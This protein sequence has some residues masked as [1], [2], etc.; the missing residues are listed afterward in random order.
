MDYP[1]QMD[2][3]AP[4]D[5]NRPVVALVGLALVPVVVAMA[6]AAVVLSRGSGGD[7]ADPPR[8]EGTPSANIVVYPTFANTSPG[9]TQSP[10]PSA[11]GG[12]PDASGGSATPGAGGG[13]GGGGGGSGGGGSGGG[14]S[15]GGGGGGGAGGGGGGSGGGGSGGG[16][17]TTTPP[18]PPPTITNYGCVKNGRLRFT[19]TVQYQAPGSVQIR[20]TQYNQPVPSW[21]DLASVQG[22]CGPG[23][24]VGVGV[25]VS[26]AGGSD[27]DSRSVICPDDPCPTCLWSPATTPHESP[28]R[29]VRPAGARLRTESQHSDR[30]P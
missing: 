14:G 13:A 18:P 27:A 25:T 2:E 28:L 26:G 11:P 20:W 15:G 12:S 1:D 4:R 9:T 23:E 6:I 5:G 24:N 19:C 17:T 3:S 10:T 7:S 30:Q 8:A 22:T 21:N 16:P 29:H